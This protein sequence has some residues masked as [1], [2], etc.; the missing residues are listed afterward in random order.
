MNRVE[1]F[2]SSFGICL[3]EFWN[4]VVPS[5]PVAAFTQN[6]AQ[7]VHKMEAL[8]ATTLIAGVVQD[9]RCSISRQKKI[10][11]HFIFK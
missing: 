2:C 8:D 6:V 7:W 10:H 9:R 1:H 3:D 4:C 5:Y 11:V